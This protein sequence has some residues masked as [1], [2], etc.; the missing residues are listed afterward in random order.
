MANRL[1]NWVGWLG[2]GRVLV[3][4]AIRVGSR[5]GVRAI[6]VR[7]E[8]FAFYLALAGL[9]C[10]L[11]YALSQWREI[12]KLFARR[13]ARYGTLAGVSIAVVLGILVAI[14]YIGSRQNKRWDLTANKQFSLSDQT[15]TIIARLDA[16]LQM[17]VFA[18]EPDFPRYREI[19]RA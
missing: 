4:L 6:G 14:N 11:A 15:K 17:T 3:A 8:Q 5:I 9:V 1:L 16:P 19:G 18:Q 12:A 13:Q 2:M 10:V 7:A